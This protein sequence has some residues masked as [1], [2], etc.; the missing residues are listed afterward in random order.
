MTTQ[1]VDQ[2]PL[3]GKTDSNWTVELRPGADVWLDTLQDNQRVGYGTGNNDHTLYTHRCLRR[4][5]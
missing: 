5:V 1:I 3:C 2:C 4:T